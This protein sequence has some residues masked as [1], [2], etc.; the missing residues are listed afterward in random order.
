MK[1][2]NIERLDF[3]LKAN[4]DKT[5]KAIFNYF[6]FSRENSLFFNLKRANETFFSYFPFQFIYTRLSKNFMLIAH[7]IVYQKFL[8]MNIDKLVAS[9][10]KGGAV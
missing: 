7:V 3:P 1:I 2:T 5:L 9:A 6:H 8:F 10:G 4:R